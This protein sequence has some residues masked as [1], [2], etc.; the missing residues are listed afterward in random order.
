MNN[1]KGLNLE[2]NMCGKCCHMEI[3]LTL[4]DI[5][6]IAESKHIKA[7]RLYKKIV[8]DKVSQ[9]SGLFKIHKNPDGGCFF[10]SKGNTCTIHEAKPN[11]CRF[12]NCSIQSKLKEM[13]WTATCTD[14]YQRVELWEQTV[15]AKITKVYI[16][17][18]DTKWNQVDYQHA[19][20]SILNNIKT[21]DS[22][23]LK[24]GR[25]SE[26]NPMGI[27]YDCSQC[28]NKGLCAK[29]TVITID[30][31]HRIC[32]YLGTTWKDFFN[33]YI[34]SKKS[35]ATGGLQLKRDQH[36]ILYNEKNNQCK[37]EQVKP[38]HCRFTPCP[39]RTKSSEMA[40]AL[41][42]GS[43]TVEQQFR[44]QVAISISREYVNNNGTQ[45]NSNSF[46]N[47]LQR[48]KEITADNNKMNE[49]LHKIAKYRYVDDTLCISNQSKP[50]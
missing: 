34:S 9:R 20:K 38:F 30:D 41:F 10:L 43:G 42:L 26:G 37:Y 21:S 33:L 45:Y 4:L 2:C 36:C 7:A 19:L 46:S 1:A 50:G 49:F 13:P 29:E 5:H 32:Q 27:L 23:K 39:T 35:K 40:D 17:K 15:A 18:N 3:P 12:Y 11:V 8:S 28:D 22:Q 44:H 31:I 16:E 24:L 6:R 25:S 14:P 48:I 47:C